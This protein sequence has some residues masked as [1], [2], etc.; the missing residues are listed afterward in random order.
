MRRHVFSLGVRVEPGVF[1]QCCGEG[2]V[3]SIAICSCAK[4]VLGPALNTVLQQTLSRIPI[5][6]CRVENYRRRLIKC[7][8]LLRPLP[9]SP[10]FSENLRYSRPYCNLLF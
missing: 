2:V 6:S 3:S 10:P 7:T 5:E 1:L 9:K 8:S 4:L